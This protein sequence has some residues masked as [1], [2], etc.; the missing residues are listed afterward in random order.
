I[1]RRVAQ[2]HAETLFWRTQGIDGTH[3]AKELGIHGG[4]PQDVVPNR[5]PPN[6]LKFGVG[7]RF[8]LQDEAVGGRWCSALP[9]STTISVKWAGR[10]GWNRSIV[11]KSCH[12]CK[13]WRYARA[14]SGKRFRA[15][16]TAGMASSGFNLSLLVTSPS[17]AAWVS[18]AC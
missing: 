17:N 15:S 12:S 11:V 4:I 16:R 18:F 10:A 1:E 2:E 5:V 14:T 7:H 9:N 8:A 13:R 6:L 3:A